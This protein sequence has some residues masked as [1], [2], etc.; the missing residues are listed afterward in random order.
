MPCDT[1]GESSPLNCWKIRYGIIDSTMSWAKNY[2]LYFHSS[3]AASDLN[4][5]LAV[6]VLSIILFYVI[7]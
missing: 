3:I 2:I 6:R 5:N 7:V 1:S 4:L